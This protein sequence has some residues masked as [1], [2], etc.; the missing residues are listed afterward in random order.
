MMVLAGDIGGTKT[1]LC[2]FRSDKRYS[3]APDIYDRV[4]FLNSD[5]ESFDDLVL[6]YICQ[7]NAPIE[8]AVF[9]VAGP[10]SNG[11]AVMTN[12]HWTLDETH[13]AASLSIPAVHVVND[14]EALALAVP[15]LKRE[16]LLV[17][18]RGRPVSGNIGVIAPGTGLG[19]SFLIP[20]NDGF[21]PHATEGGHADFAPRSDLEIRLLA[22]L[23]EQH[24]H[25]SYERVCSGTAIVDLYRFLNRIEGI[26][27]PASLAGRLSS[28]ADPTAAI[29]SEA[30]AA[31]DPSNLCRCTLE[32]FVTILGAESGNLALTTMAVGGIYLGGG[33]PRR[34][35]KFLKPKRFMTAFLNKGRMSELLSHI[36]VYVIL[37]PAATLYGAACRALIP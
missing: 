18:H 14:L 7:R 13:L 32:L 6:D 35:A 15:R 16:D 24:A 8:R 33:I 2:I 23:M 5:I 10:V 22:Y 17:L 4:T 20:V 34:I 30:L 21:V 36:S 19:E 26:P 37:N 28:F 25:V 11:R 27:E 31:E 29:V 1:D 3:R 9:A 12:F